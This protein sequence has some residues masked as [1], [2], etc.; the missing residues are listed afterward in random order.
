MS[1]SLSR[2]RWAAVLN[3]CEIFINLLK[4][5]LIKSI[6]HVQVL[7]RENRSQVDVTIQC[8]DNGSPSLTSFAHLSI[9]LADINDNAPLFTETEYTLTVVENNPHHTLVGRVEA[10]D[11][12]RGANGTVRYRLGND[13]THY[14]YSLDPVSGG[15]TALSHMN[16]EQHADDTLMVGANY[17]A[18]E[19]VEHFTL[20][21]A[22]H[23]LLSL[24]SD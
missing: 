18:V 21:C 23:I 1:T 4:R 24:Y 12:D 9:H 16:R 5:L 15:L 7:D 6:E 22:I 14:A 2:L 13:H 8:S 3:S 20:N 11:P 19:L 17:C 10:R